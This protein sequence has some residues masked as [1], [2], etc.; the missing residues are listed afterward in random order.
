MD[1]QLT[2]AEATRA[3][4]L[5]PDL[6]G[7]DQRMA[8]CEQVAIPLQESFVSGMY[9]RQITIPAGTF[10]TG[11]AYKH[12]YID[13]MTGG[14]I[15]VATPDGV[16]ERKGANTMDGKAGRRRMGY[17]VEDTPWI[18][19]HQYGLEGRDNVLDRIS[20]LTRGDWEVWRDQVDYF[21]ALHENGITPEQVAEE[22][23]N[24]GDVVW[25]SS[26]PV[27]SAPSKRE[28]VG[29][30]AACDIIGG[31]AF[32]PAR[33]A[34]GRRTQAGRYTNHGADPNCRFYEPGDGGVMM[35]ALRTIR[36]GEEL[37]VNYRNVMRM[38]EVA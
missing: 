8:A 13:I 22:T 1:K 24:G 5:F 10:L 30:F 4:T 36:A 21:V 32:M 9:M 19:V 27:I 35:Q 15:L 28:G 20:F 29:L 31:H 25:L 17:A 16:I 26:V 3:L 14:H 11:R 37:T 23:A 12:D 7:F 34:D 38:R 6:D 33:L 2:I 18:T